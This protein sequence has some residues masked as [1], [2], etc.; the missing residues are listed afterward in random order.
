MPK[1]VK[2]LYWT[3]RK[4]LVFWN[5]NGQFCIIRTN[6]ETSNISYVQIPWT[7][8]TICICNSVYI[9]DWIK[10]FMTSLLIII[11]VI[12]WYPSNHCPHENRCTIIIRV[13]FCHFVSTKKTM[14]QY[15]IE[16]LNKQRSL[17]I[18]CSFI[19]NLN[20]GFFPPLFK[21]W[22]LRMVSKG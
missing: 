21:I 20:N 16:C 9:Y 19:L 15:G 12:S 6:V 18:L 10:C 22:T 2:Y 14:I 1:T 3:T 8:I 4:T 17:S 11:H 5:V 13:I 7:F